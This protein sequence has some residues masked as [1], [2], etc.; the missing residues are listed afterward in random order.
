MPTRER[1]ALFLR[2]FALQGSW[3]YRTLI[4]AGL[5][6]VLMPTLRRLHA[7]DPERLRKAVARHS[8]LFNSH[9]YFSGVAIGAVAAL[10]SEGEEPAVVERFKQALRGSLGTVGDRLFWAGWRPVTV[11]LALALLLTG[12][13][14]WAAVGGFLLAYNVVHL[15]ARVWGFRVGFTEGRRVGER[16]RRSGLEQADRG[17]EW[18]GPFLAGLLLPLVAAG[19]LVGVALPWPWAGAAAIGGLA[20]ALAGG[21]VRKPAELLLIAFVIAALLLG[22]F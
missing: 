16:L 6:F 22:A 8:G 3:N 9:P 1:I 19:G 18:A 5:A 15:T 17:L 4:G 20:G 12:A 10:E 2:S 21:R 11:L 14:G 13:P 7:G